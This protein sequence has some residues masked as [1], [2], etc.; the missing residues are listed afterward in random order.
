[1]RRLTSIVSAAALTG[2]GIIPVATAQAAPAPPSTAPPSTASTAAD[3]QP[4]PIDWGDCASASMQR[5]GAQCGLLTVPLDYANP[6][7]QKIKIGVSRIEHKTSDA[8]YQGIMLVN[9]GGPGGSGLNLARIG[10]F[11]PHQAG[12]PYDWI[13]FD[14]RGVGTS[15]PRLSCDGHYTTLDR[16]DYIPSTAG[17]E[18]FW[19]NK[20]A[21]YAD[22]CAE[23]GGELLDHMRTT[24]NVND[25]ES[26]RKALGAEQI[27]Y[28][29]FSYG[30]YLGQVYATLHPDRVRRM[31]FDG[32]V[33]PEDAW[34]EANLNQDTAFEKS[35]R[36]WF[37]WI[38][39]HDATYHLGTDGDQVRA[40]WYDMR[41]QARASSFDG[42]IGPAEW[43][44]VF[45]GAGYYVYSWD[46]YAQAFADAVNGDYGLVEAIF[47]DGGPSDD[48]LYAVYLSTECTDAR[49][50]TAWPRWEADNWRTHRVAPFETW[51]NAW[52]NAPCHNWSGQAQKPVKV[53]G[54]QVPPIL[55]IEETHDAA[56]PWAGAIKVR[57]LFPR[58]VLI[59]GVGGSTHAGSLSGV[60]CTDDRIADYLL[61]GQLDA[62]Q[63]GRGSDVQCPP[64]PAPEP[65]PSTSARSLAPATAPAGAGLPADPR[66]LIALPVR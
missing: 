12:D 35:M 62:R 14:P 32:V 60:S 47:G 23:A 33:T 44:D 42:K 38:A 22:D 15:E 10:A 40:L 50:P 52:F 55:L 18:Q 39:D 11:V 54:H 51:A 13:G 6:D 34:Y 21:T 66:Q 24:D 49:W 45:L 36:I 5:A 29:G 16:P 9:P 17:I 57:Q 37:D 4:P 8:D 63:P 59:E 25:M 31:V 30:T 7:G 64:V 26:I 41:D 19:L 1:M 20:T 27:N 3:Y 43:T 61:T 58:S 2:L 48:N 53:D 46:V 28:Y 65:E 56:T